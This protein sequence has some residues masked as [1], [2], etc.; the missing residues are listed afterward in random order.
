M[1]LDLVDGVRIVG[2][3]AFGFA[4]LYLFCTDQPQ[5]AVVALATGVVALGHLV[6][7]VASRTPPEKAESTE[8]A[9]TKVEAD[10][11]ERGVKLLGKE[12]QERLVD[13]E[14]RNREVTKQYVAVAGVSLTIIASLGKEAP[15]T[16]V[17]VGAS[18][19]GVSIAFALVLLERLTGSTVRDFG[20]YTLS[21][22]YHLMC[23][24]L[25]F[26]LLSILAS[27]WS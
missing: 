3:T 18:S 22:M 23:W 12:L 10:E 7:T 6:I 24:S 5:L 19:L 13:E 16:E 25:L 17:L 9:E 26:G 15:T 27:L 4:A 20:H 11:L 1:D 14:A 8:T 21:I 2:A